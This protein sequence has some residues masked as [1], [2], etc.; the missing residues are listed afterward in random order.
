[1]GVMDTS[2]VKDEYICYVDGRG[3]GNNDENVAILRAT[4]SHCQPWYDKRALVHPVDTKTPTSILY[5]HNIT[6]QHERERRKYIQK[7]TVSNQ[8]IYTYNVSS[9]KYVNFGPLPSNG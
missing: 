4:P 7:D 1:M 3:N 9:Y 2:G 6:T 5:T 8:Y